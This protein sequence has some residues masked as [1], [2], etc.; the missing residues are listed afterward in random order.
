MRKT[1]MT[2]VAVAIAGSGLAA[3]SSNPSAGHGPKSSA[4]PALVMESS[5]ETAITQAFNPFVP[6]Q[7]AYGM[8]A[9]GLIYEPL[10]QFD[11]A[12][13]PKRKKENIRKRKRK[14]K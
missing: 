2:L 8:G 10:I 13:P 12:A 3:C 1:L 14:I 7:A 6:T 5:P 11:L 9:T 4:I